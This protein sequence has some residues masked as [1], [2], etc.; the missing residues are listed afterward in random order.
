[1]STKVLILFYSTY[2]H[3]HKLALAA[4]KGAKK[5]GAEVR[6][7]RIPETLPKEVLEKLNAVEAQKVFEDV[8]LATAEDL[9]WA[10]GHL[11]GAPTRFGNIPAQVKTFQETLGQ[12]WLAQIKGQGLLGKPAGAFTSAGNQHGGVETTIVN[13]FW[14]FF[15]HMGQIIVGLP[16]NFT[17]QMGV[18]EVKGG[19]PYGASTVVGHGERQPSETDLAGA[20]YQGEYLAKIA[21]KLTNN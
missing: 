11:W 8:P 6:L 18:D 9:L 4:E 16:Y 19:S 2:G 17:G 12:V 13:G 1:M 15:S 7:R 3:I 21:A 20:E 5:A 10:D 14:A